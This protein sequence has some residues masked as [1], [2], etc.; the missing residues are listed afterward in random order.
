MRN[1]IIHYHI[2]KN[3]GSSIDR[4][5]EQ[6]FG[7]AWSTLEG[8]TPTSLLT[9][10][11]VEDYLS[12]HPELQAVS[13]HLA[14]PPLPSNVTAFPIVFI[15]HPLDR[16]AS[17]Y[18]HEHRVPSNVESAEIAKLR[19]FAGYVKWCL[20]PSEGRMKGGVVIRNYQVV[21]LSKASFRSQHVYQA[22]ALKTDLD[23]VL[24]L[25]DRLPFFGIVEEFEAS[26]QLLKRKLPPLWSDFQVANLQENISP[27]R[28]VTLQARLEKIEREL[29]P[30]VLRWFLLENQLDMELYE[31]ALAK[32]RGRVAAEPPQQA[33]QQAKI[34]GQQP[35][36]CSECG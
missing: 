9:V 18:S 30:D 20:D 29:G 2:F 8:S 33:D 16:A 12:I 23:D 17:V 32:F 24:S 19:D 36:T 4:L 11:E 28:E 21:H 13:S 22:E 6:N 26:L 25:L 10:R 15:R 1:V 3:A 14:R 27:G 7:P 31:T 35:H 34:R 5:L